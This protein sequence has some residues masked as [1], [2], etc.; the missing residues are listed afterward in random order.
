VVVT[1]AWNVYRWGDV[2]APKRTGCGWAQTARYKTGAAATGVSW[3]WYGGF[4]FSVRGVWAWRQ[5]RWRGIHRRR[6]AWYD[7]AEWLAAGRSAV[8]A[9][10]GAA[11]VLR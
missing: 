8:V 4:G 7:R 10:N 1:R 9:A 5:W 11:A 3:A 2:Q 6:R